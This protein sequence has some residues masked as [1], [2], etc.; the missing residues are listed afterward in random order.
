[1]RYVLTLLGGAVLGALLVLFFLGTPRV[2]P[3]PGAPVR[4]PDPNAPPEAGTALVT[5]DEKFFDALL[6]SI[7][8]DMGGPSFRLSSAQNGDAPAADLK[9]LAAAFQGGCPSVVVLAP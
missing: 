7:F 2:K 1:M 8:R 6:G 9:F 3:L 5:L 4:A